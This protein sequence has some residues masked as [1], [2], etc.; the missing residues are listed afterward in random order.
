MYQILEANFFYGTVFAL[1]IQKLC[2][3]LYIMT[4]FTLMLIFF[5]VKSLNAGPL[6]VTEYFLQRGFTFYANKRSE[7]FC[8]KVI[9]HQ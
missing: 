6:C 3:P 5:F 2:V 8:P 1:Q 7:Y 4:T 9:I